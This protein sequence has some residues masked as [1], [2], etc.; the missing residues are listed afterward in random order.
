LKD[1]FKR[2]EARQT[3]TG[4]S[5]KEELLSYYKTICPCCGGEADIIYT[6]WVKMVS[7]ADPRHH[8]VPLFSNYIISQKY[9]SI[10]FTPD[11]SCQKCHKT[12]DLDHEPA[13]FVG[14]HELMI[15]G[16]ID[17]AGDGRSNKRWAVWTEDK[18]RVNCPWCKN[19]IDVNNI[20]ILKKARKKVSLNTLLCPS[21]SAVWQFRGSLPD[22]VECP[23]CSNHYDPITG[24]MPDKGYKCP[25]CGVKEAVIDAIRKLP[26]EK[27]LSIKPYAVEGW[28]PNCNGSDTENDAGPIFE[29]LAQYNTGNEAHTCVLKKSNGKF[30]KKI[31]PEDVRKYQDAEK[32]WETF[33]GKLP[34]PISKVPDGQETHRLI[35]HHYRHWYQMFNVRQLLCLGL[36]L[37]AID[38]EENQTMKEMLLS[39]FHNLINNMSDF[40][41]Y[42]PQR[43]CIRQVFARHDFQPKMTICESTVWGTNIGMGSYRSLFDAVIRAKSFCVR[44]YDRLSETSDNMFYDKEKIQ[45]TELDNIVCGN[46]IDAIT[47][48]CNITITDPPYAGNVNY[49]ELADFFYV[50]LRLVLRRNY[51]WFS[52]EYSPKADEI[53]ENATRGKTSRDY[54]DG[55]TKVWAKCHAAMGDDGVLVFTFHHAEDSAWEALLESICKSGFYLEAV[56]PIHGEAESSMNLIGNQAISYDL[57]HVCKKRLLE[58]DKKVSWAGIRQEIRRKAR[59]EIKLIESGR[60]GKEKLSDADINM[61]LI[62]KCLQYYSIH[63]GNIID[64]KDEVVPLREALSS[65]RMMVEQFVS[66]TNP[67]PSELEHIDPVSYVYF[68]CLCDRTEIKVDEVSMAIRGLI[69]PEA[70][71]KEGIMKKGRAG[72]GRTYEVKKPSERAEALD[73]LFGGSDERILQTTLF[74]EME[75]ARFDKIP[76]VNVIHH[77]MN[78]AAAGDNLAPWLQ[79]FSAVRPQIRAGME[80]VI[81]RNPTFQE[82]VRKV[83][84]LM[85]V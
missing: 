56:Y 30:F 64:Y 70:L 63:Y 83:L 3:M 55:L 16:G 78:I 26:E 28:C 15:N 43:D 68:T 74:P 29:P 24:N 1:A 47:E 21:C 39:A 2:L 44:P 76:L 40:C 9:P 32:N 82:P 22:G 69:E 61:V 41:T 42:I 50:W 7:C 51:P 6:F 19:I 54:S 77:L 46:S 33:K 65:I 36:L 71:L 66:S 48:R 12:F 20:S 72:R 38:E 52:P 27:L 11:F 23:V 53:V 49:S 59:E 75:E 60:Y 80:Y 18:K 25:S 8:Q 13:S 79:R 14:K 85:E 17:S 62:G 4:K 10:R 57:I 37:H 67:L 58:S 31:E 84:N 35:E 73:K 5:V 45:R 34:Y 81:K